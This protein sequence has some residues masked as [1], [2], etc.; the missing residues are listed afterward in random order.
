MIIRVDT[1]G[2]LTHPQIIAFLK[3]AA[4]AQSFPN[5]EAAA[6]EL[7]QRISDPD[8]GVWFGIEEGEL[9]AVCVAM[10]PVST[11]QVRPQVIFAYNK[12]SSALWLDIGK[13]VRAWMKA[14][15]FN[16]A[17]FVNRSGHRDEVAQR[18]WKALGNITTVGSIL[19]FD[20]G[21]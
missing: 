5:V 4:E 17:W 7:D 8:L 13:I 12:G 21:E 6:A 3:E 15:G 2:P 14:A 18:A 1:P 16:Q 11:F 10:L 19:E 20:L 9:V